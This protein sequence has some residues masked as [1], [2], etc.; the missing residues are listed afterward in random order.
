[1]G[2]VLELPKTSRVNGKR[3]RPNNEHLPA[4]PRPLYSRSREILGSWQ[5]MPELCSGCVNK[6]DRLCKRRDCGLDAKVAVGATELDDRADRA[7]A[8]L[9]KA[10]LVSIK[11]PQI[12]FARIIQFIAVEELLRPFE[13]ILQ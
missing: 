9:P 2:F 3:L 5:R 11:C 7:M 12:I 1:M 8:P 6:G 4:G 13:V 10:L